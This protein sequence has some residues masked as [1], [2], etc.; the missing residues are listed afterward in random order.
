MSEQAPGPLPDGVMHGPYPDN[1]PQ[2]FYHYDAINDALYSRKIDGQQHAELIS[3]AMKL[4][5]IEREEKAENQHSNDTVESNLNGTHH[6]SNEHEDTDPLEGD[7]DK[8]VPSEETRTDAQIEQ[9]EVFANRS[10]MAGVGDSDEY[11]TEY[12][13]Y[14]G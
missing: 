2:S 7:V 13:E 12:D 8:F 4:Q 1:A 9:D 6:S 11:W 3:N 14:N 5:D 10:Y